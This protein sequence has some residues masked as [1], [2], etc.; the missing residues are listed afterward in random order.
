MVFKERFANLTS[1]KCAPKSASKTILKSIPRNQ[2]EK[3]HSKSFLQSTSKNLPQKAYSKINRKNIPQKIHSKTNPKKLF[4]QNFSKLTPSFSA[5][6]VNTETREQDFAVCIDQIRLKVSPAVI[7]L[8]S[9][10]G[11]S[12]SENRGADSDASS[13]RAILREYPD[14]WLPKKLD[15]SDYWWF[16]ELA[17]EAD[18]G[19]EEAGEVEIAAPAITS[20]RVEFRIDR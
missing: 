3:V 6:T 17:E 9:A 16:T 10:V 15:H 11:A 14:Y 12:F 19:L 4:F 18:E 5:G 7:R 13:G 20:E 8:L 1:K 2:P